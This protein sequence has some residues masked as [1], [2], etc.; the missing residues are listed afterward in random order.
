MILT[1][2][3]VM[4]IMLFSAWI[5]SKSQ[6]HLPDITILNQP[7]NKIFISGLF[8]IYQFVQ[9]I[10][11]FQVWM[12]L[13]GKSDL[14]F[15][16]SILDSILITIFLL[17]FAFIFLNYNKTSKFKPSGIDT[18][19]AVVLGAAVWR[20]EPSPSLKSRVDKAL[21][22]YK[23]GSIHKIQLTGGNAPG[24]LSEAEIALA[25]LKTKDIDTNDV[26]IEK[27]TTSTTEQIQFIK[28]R[29]DGKPGIGNIIVISD[30]YHLPR[31]KEIADFYHLKIEVAA[32]DLDLNYANKIY[33]KVRESAAILIF[34][35][36]A[37]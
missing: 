1:L 31:V 30:S 4:T 19:T 27:N 34:W 7:F 28:S 5:F 15:L 18:N 37:I 29:L 12:N 2:S 33:Y 20:N 9:F 25:Y 24:E 11:I 26:W 13:S 8:F 17:V 22:L 10:L 14:I 35:F 21:S 16:R 3:I 32:S 23:K 6:V 36:F